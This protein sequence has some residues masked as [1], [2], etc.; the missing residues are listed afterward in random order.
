MAAGNPLHQPHGDGS[1]LEADQK[2]LNPPL[3]PYEK[4]L[5]QLLGCSEAEYKTLLRFNNLLERTRPAGYD[6]IPDVVNS[7]TTAIIVNLVIGLALT[8]AS[9]LLTPKP[10]IDD[11]RDRKKV[12]QEQLPNDV[13]PSRF[14][15]TSSFDGFASLIDYGIPVPIAFGKMVLEGNR[16]VS[17]G[18]V[19]AASLV[20][21]RA[22]SYGT[23][24]RI[25]LL[26]TLGQFIL[27]QPIVRG[28]WLGTQSLS[29]LGGSEYALYWK[30]QQGENR[31]KKTDAALIG[32]TAGTPE[33]GDPEDN[34]SK[35]SDDVFIAPVDG[36]IEGPGFCMVNNPQ[37]KSLFGQFNPVRNGTAHR[38]NWE[39]ISVPFDALKKDTEGDVTTDNIDPD[40]ARRAR[41][42][43]I[44]VAG[45]FAGVLF[46]PGL[47]GQ[48]GVG[49]AYGTRMGLI[50]Y[51]PPGSGFVETNDKIPF[52][53]ITPG[54]QVKFR[55]NGANWDEFDKTEY[56]YSNRQEGT[57]RQW[58]VTHKDLT[59]AMDARR[60]RADDLFS[61]GS[62]WMIGPTQ[63]LVTTRTN[64]VWRPGTEV[65]VILEC[66]STTG[67]PQI[68]IAG[69]RAATEPLGGYE[70]P[71]VS[72]I[73]GSP[74]P[75]FISD[76]GFNKKK[77]CGAA[78]WNLVQYEVATARMTRLADTVEFGIKSTVWNQ[79]NGL[80]NFNAIPTPEDL[81]KKD[82][83]N[84]T[85]N[86]PTTSRYFKRTSCFSLF[87]RPI[88]KFEDQELSPPEWKRLNPVFCVTGDSPRAMYNYI[89]IRPDV[90]GLY[91]F[92]FI[93]RVGSDIAINSD[94]EVFFYQLNAT[95]GEV[96]GEDFFVPD[97]GSF[98]VT[99]TG[100]KI[101]C[102]SVL[103][104]EELVSDP[105][106]VQAPPPEQTKI[107]TAIANYAWSTGADWHKNAWLTE[108]FGRDPSF[109]GQTGTAS[110]VHFKPR[111]SG[112][113]DDGYIHVR[114]QATASTISGPR[115]L[116]NFGTNLNWAG[117]GSSIRFSVIQD[118]E[119]RGQWKR[120]DLFTITK[121]ISTSNR[122]YPWNP[123][124]VGAAF[125]VT[126][127]KDG[128]VTGDI[129]FGDGDRAFE[130]ASQVSDCSHYDEITKSCDS[131]PEHEIVYLNNAVSEAD[132]EGTDGIPQYTDL[133][134]LGLSLKSG[135]SIGAIEQP[136][137]WVNGGIG[138]T[139][140]ANNDV[141]GVSNLLSDL[142][143][144]LLKDDKQGLGE[145]IPDELIDK[146]SFAT[147][148]KYLLENGIYWNGVVESDANFRSFATDQA[149]KNLCI[150]TIKNGV[151]GMMPALPVNSEQ[152]IS[153]DPIAVEGAFAQ[154]NIIDGSFKLTFIGAEERRPSALQVR[155]RR[156]QPY[157]LPE[158]RT[159][160]VQFADTSPEN[161]EDYDLTQFCDNDAQALL[162]AR[163]AL[164]SRRFID[165]T[166]EFKTTPEAVGVQPGSYIKLFVE[167][168]EFQA[169]LALRIN[170][171]MTV[172]SP[173]P[174][175]DGFY[176]LSAYLPGATEVI[177][178]GT[179]IRNGVAENQE[180]R[181]A[182][183]SVYDTTPYQRIYQISEITLDEDGLV[184]I[185]ASVVPTQSDESST[186][187]FY[188]LNAD[189]FTV[190]Q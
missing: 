103:F 128:Q 156:T 150:F 106:K 59:S 135:P 24:Q 174:L 1:G 93:P 108:V 58:G 188:T 177:E 29:A 20:W 72:L 64:Q 99:I 184:N 130:E 83:D 79:A 12:R 16:Y 155:W 81:F 146:T 2:R 78:F 11:Q 22:Y 131:G 97:Y 147:T 46:D 102:K 96:I 148:G 118:S 28:V 100:Q 7:P 166:V 86:T 89:R 49:R 107:P 172:T 51:A 111:N 37:S 109:N 63:W 70:G 105:A 151:F 35:K 138:V 186:I 45:E 71:W 36:T 14:N 142:L 149:Q 5:I 27:A 123:G 18:L 104:N 161:I 180:L 77:H 116:Q 66:V 65:E 32:G 25:K 53:R 141:F 164:A 6:H 179:L 88:P 84:I 175:K 57:P 173:E 121:S 31:I 9:V 127:V 126:S 56:F 60:S 44:K 39:V 94:P 80:C 98:R 23:Y 38:I 160:I 115:H 181:G 168:T 21:S 55:I 110:T 91:E 13:G 47:G 17:G 67:E 122:Y 157:E 183:A 165:H 3:L 43:R 159:A 140:L 162:T 185:S 10:Q 145:I 163:F 182:I 15:Q 87:V 101:P 143:Y 153:T 133:A 73:A 34:E 95:S 171:D 190:I 52:L 82:S 54:Y 158:D 176:T 152:A 136:R 41:A 68:G 33:S 69:L 90:S 74:K 129:T 114:I 8:A 26:Y 137:V 139:R 40:G 85:V 134:M 189:Q 167:E 113:D 48:P 30:S 61:I 76:K 19:L 124:T 120:G 92:R 132:G 178:T 187:A 117:N 42:E 75:D 170:D 50:A 154:G 169:G 112:A 125:Q 119:T 4:D 62:R 144:Y